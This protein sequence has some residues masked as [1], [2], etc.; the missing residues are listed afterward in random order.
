MLLAGS[1]T[2]QLFMSLFFNIAFFDASPGYCAVQ[3]EMMF[4]VT[5]V[6]TYTFG[7][8]VISISNI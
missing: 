7:R 1:Y 3:H 6:W 2:I 5:S 4:S 8:A